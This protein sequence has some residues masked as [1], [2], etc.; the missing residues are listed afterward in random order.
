M[1]NYSDLFI[2]IFLGLAGVPV[3]I[4]LTNLLKGLYDVGKYNVLYAMTAGVALNLIGVLFFTAY[5][6]QSVVAAAFVGLLVGLA[7]SG[8]Y[9]LVK[10]PAK[11]NWDY[12]IDDE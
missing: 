5:S 3:V 11:A 1:P 2:R 10:L 4:S 9:D 8:L 7:A 6:V 12:S